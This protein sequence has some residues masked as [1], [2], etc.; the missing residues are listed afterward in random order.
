MEYAWPLVQIQPFHSTTLIPPQLVVS[1]LALITTS[2][3][4]FWVDA[5]RREL[6]QMDIMLT[7]LPEIASLT[8]RTQFI[9]TKTAALCHVWVN[10]LLATSVIILSA[11]TRNA[12][13]HAKVHGLLTILPGHVCRHAQAILPT[14]Q[15]QPPR[16]ALVSAEYN[17]IYT[18]TTERTFAL[19]LIHVQVEPMLTYTLKDASST[20]FSTQALTCMSM[21]QKEHAILPARQAIL[22]ITQLGSVSLAVPLRPTT[23][24]IGYRLLVFQCVPKQPPPNITQTHPPEHAWLPVPLLSMELSLIVMLCWGHAWR[25]VLAIN[26]RIPPLV[27]VW[28]N[29]Q[30]VLIYSDKSASKNVCSAVTLP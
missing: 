11:T 2:R 16:P 12:W 21:E 27:I 22:P 7:L 28:R 18:H 24:Q 30:A 1:L 29:V 6:V 4:I 15:T 25:F 26:L 13:L 19:V 8:V 20:V 9:H 17:S 10:V 3:M 14:T 23:S 5:C